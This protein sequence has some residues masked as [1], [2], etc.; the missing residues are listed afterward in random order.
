MVPEY[1]DRTNSKGLKLEILNLVVFKVT[2]GVYLRVAT[3]APYC[4]TCF[5]VILKTILKTVGI[6]SMLTKL[7]K[8]VD[9]DDDWRS[10]Q[11]SLKSFASWSELNGLSLNAAKCSSISF[12]KHK[13]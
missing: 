2:S 4:L 3:V 6:C 1:V 7:F 10:L 8:I 9:D 13:K 5:Y 12:L 11:E